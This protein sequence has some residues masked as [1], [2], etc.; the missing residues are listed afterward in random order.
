M[1][2]ASCHTANRKI[3]ANCYCLG[4]DGDNR[5]VANSGEITVADHAILDFLRIHRMFADAHTKRGGA[6]H[7]LFHHHVVRDIRAVVSEER[8]ARLGKRFKIGDFVPKP[9][10]RNTGG[11]KKEWG[12]G[13]VME[14]RSL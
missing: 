9:T 7:R 12:S 8:S 2:T 6:A 5:E 3:A 1:K 10:F 11:G 13:G 4:R 14:W